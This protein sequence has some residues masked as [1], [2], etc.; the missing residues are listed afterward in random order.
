MSWRLEP[1]PA[2]TRPSHFETCQPSLLRF[3]PVCLRGPS[4]VPVGRFLRLCPVGG[5]PY[6][7]PPREPLEGLLTALVTTVQG[8][9]VFEELSVPIRSRHPSS[10]FLD[11]IPHPS[12][13]V[14][15]SI[16][17]DTG[18]LSDIS[19]HSG[20]YVYFGYGRG[21]PEAVGPH[22]RSVTHPTSPWTALS[23]PSAGSH[24]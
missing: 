20:R 11:L 5:R 21:V 4:N 23:R 18:S 22:Q 24:L 16:G 15:L 19:L 9:S 12:E 6:L 14:V 13:P 10:L 3:S 7:L 2:P 8:P 17:R 1:T